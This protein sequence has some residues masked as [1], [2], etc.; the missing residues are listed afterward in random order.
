MLLQE[1]E[2]LYRL[3]PVQRMSHVNSKMSV[4]TVEHLL[5]ETC[6]VVEGGQYGGTVDLALDLYIGF[7]TRIQEMGVY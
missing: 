7:A 3:G 2:T 6:L 4:L 1:L 5:Q